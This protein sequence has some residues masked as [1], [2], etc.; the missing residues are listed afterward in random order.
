[1]TEQNRD[2][3]LGTDGADQLGGTPAKTDEVQTGVGREPWDNRSG[4]GDTGDMGN[5]GDTE[6]TPPDTNSGERNQP[7]SGG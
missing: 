4:E 6:V 5:T 7:P 2:R 1:M 3:D